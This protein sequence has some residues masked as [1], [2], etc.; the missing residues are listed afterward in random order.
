MSE[1]LSPRV[2]ILL[3]AYNG[4][5][6]IEQTLRS[7]LDQDFDDFE[8]IV[9]DDCSSDNTVSV[10]KGMYDSRVQCFQHDHNLGYSGN[11]AR[12]AKYARGGII[13]LMGQDDILLCGG[14]RSTINA[15]DLHEDIGVVTRPY[16]WFYDDFKVPV[17]DVKPYNR[18]VD[19]VFSLFDGA[20]VIEAAFGSFGQLSGLAIR[21]ALLGVDFH[22]HIFTSHIYPVADVLRRSRGVFLHE[23]TVAV[24]IRSSQTRH[25]SEIYSPPPL[26][27]WVELVN[28]VFGDREFL[29]VNRTLMRFLGRSNHVDLIQIRN[30]STWGTLFREILMFIRLRPMNAVDIRFIMVVAVCV[31]V[32]RRQLR[33]L[34]DAYKIH[35]LSR[36]IARE[37]HA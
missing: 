19:V 5:A 12:A 13:F 27:T 7:I 4:E 3:P 37:N 31:V 33:A 6:V 36:V 18:H 11:L 20:D 1:K 28:S 22:G 25:K 17:R 35:F 29:Q 8:I 26:L 21:K 16:Y 15:F 10:V 32:P 14:L 24:R 34:V 23:F 9:S 2:S 30:Y